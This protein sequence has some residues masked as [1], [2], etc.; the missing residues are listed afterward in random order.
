M[1]QKYHLISGPA[2]REEGFGGMPT[3]QAMQAASGESGRAEPT[4]E[5]FLQPMD[6][7][8][9][10]IPQMGASE[11][12]LDVPG[13]EPYPAGKQGMEPRVASF[14]SAVHAAAPVAS[15]ESVPEPVYHSLP[16]PHAE[17][18]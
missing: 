7:P 15:T 10:F 2:K 8:P 4:Q 18:T 5:A 11:A 3:S 1:V 6:A 16:Q 12:A 13:A 14:P 17:L 9:V